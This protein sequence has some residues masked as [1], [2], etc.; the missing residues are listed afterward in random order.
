MQKCY[1]DSNILISLKDETSFFHNQAKDLLK[2][3]ITNSFK[4]YISPL[5]LDEFLFQIKFIFQKKDKKE[6]EVFC[7]SAF[8]EIL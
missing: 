6:V 8:K 7:F 1:L 5:V 3:L 2:K 4:L